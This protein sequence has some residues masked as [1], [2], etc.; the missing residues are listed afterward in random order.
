MSTFNCLARDEH[1][2]WDNLSS[3]IRVVD[4]VVPKVNAKVAVPV[5]EV[6]ISTY[7]LQEKPHQFI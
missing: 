2:I 6:D 5:E 4:V 7:T 1:S 3:Q